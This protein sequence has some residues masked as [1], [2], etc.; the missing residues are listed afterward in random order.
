MAP[1]N[2]GA[3]ILA[4]CLLAIGVSFAFSIAL[5]GQDVGHEPDKHETGSNDDE[6]ANST[7]VKLTVLD[8]NHHPIPGAGI[9]V[10]CWFG[11]QQYRTK[12][13][14]ELTTNAEG[15][16]EVK[17]L[18]TLER[19]RFW[20]SA[21]DHVTLFTGFE[22][23]MLANIPPAITMHLQS[24]QSIGGKVVDADGQPV[25]GA[26]IEIKRDGGGVKL[27]TNDF[28]QLNT[29][30][31]DGED[32]VKTDEHGNWSLDQRIP[33]GDDLSLSFIVKHPD[34]LGDK[35]W[36]PMGKK[37][38]TL[39]QLKSREAEFSLERGVRI[40]G[41]VVDDT[42]NPIG[43]A[44]VVWGDRPYWEQGSQE[45][46]TD[47]QGN[48]E[49]PALESK[50]IRL[51]VVAKGWMP[52]L[53]QIDLASPNSKVKFEMAKGRKLH[54]RF[55]D[56]EGN[57]V[58]NVSVSLKKW[59][60][61][62][63]LYNIKH[64]NVIDSQIPNISDK[65]GVYVW[66]WAPDDEL[67]I[68]TGNR[69]FARYT[70]RR[71]IAD[72]TIQTIEIKQKFYFAGTLIDAETQQPINDFSITPVT[73][74]S[75]GQA[76][77]QNSRTKQFRSSNFKLHTTMFS[78]HEGNVKFEIEAMDYRVK[79][80]DEFTPD[81]D[82]YDG[83]IA[84]VPV[85]APRGRVLDSD[86]KAVAGASIFVCTKDNG[87]MINR[88]DDYFQ[89]DERMYKSA[90][91]GS[92][93][94]PAQPAR[95]AITIASPEGYAERYLE[96]DQDPGEIKI[97][98]WSTIQGRLFQEG[99]PVADALVMASPIRTLGN[100]NPH[101]Q[102]HFSAMTDKEGRFVFDKIP[103]VPCSIR[104]HLSPWDDF[105]ITSSRSLAIKLEPGKTHEVSLGGDGIQLI[106]KVKLKGETTDHIEFRYGLNT[107]L[108]IGSR[109]ELAEHLVNPGKFSVGQ[110]NED[111]LK[112]TDGTGSTAGYE[113]H[114]VKLNPDGSFLVNGV[115]PGE[116]RFHF[117][118]F[119]P[120]S[121]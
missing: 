56:P 46:K 42:G 116:Y 88:F 85:R 91:D 34:F 10:G 63:S 23:G 73:C 66:D 78:G 61:A 54:L 112:L 19:I 72:D 28:T 53:K 84:M 87:A 107:L 18:P 96:S 119:E 62:E 47:S 115:A 68:Q 70:E 95:V 94:Y 83:T 30:I 33:E 109:I 40:R 49:L 120:P 31:A 114:F 67:V 43:D 71:L 38:V 108:K 20:V 21:K 6:F 101:L 80:T 55:V 52:Q 121:G 77:V 51:T 9:H 82:P 50:P 5:H 3:R 106:G 100:E 74:Y 59:R 48:F 32:I 39:R 25:E 90:S 15:V 37:D 117:R 111:L 2:Y 97:M 4:A 17:L 118:I 11:D 81:S 92:F 65:N 105:P 7:S 26:E 36:T 75:N 1:P 64:P 35:H 99:E 13:D 93:K 79:Y 24:S 110:K 113:S 86:G 58:P 57:A 29:W 69:E 14:R 12:Y 98:P 76:I 103:P 44:L 89:T 8:S 27:D 41:I 60:G 22:P 102:D 45:L 16:A 104:S